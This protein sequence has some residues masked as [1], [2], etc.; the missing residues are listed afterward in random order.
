MPTSRIRHQPSF[1]RELLRRGELT[2][3]L[4]LIDVG[5]SGGID[6]LWNV[7]GERLRAVGFDPLVKEVA[8]LN[9]ENG[10]PKVNY[11]AAFV[12]C[13]RIPEVTTSSNPFPRTSAAAAA[14]LLRMNY[15]QEKFNAG[16]QVVWSDR[17]VDLDEYFS[18]ADAPAVDF[19]KIDTDGHDFH[20]LLGAERLLRDGGVL[21]LSVESQLH[22]DSH[23]HANTFANLDRFLRGLGFMLFDLE[24]H[25]YSRAVLPSP[26]VC[27]IPAQT[28]DGQVQWGEAVYFRDL[29]AMTT[30]D[31]P[32]RWGRQKLLKLASLFE[33]FGLADCAVEL[34][35]QHRA[36][37]PELAGLEWLDLLT[38]PLHG[39]RLSYDRYL[40]RFRDVESFY[41]RQTS[42]DGASPGKMSRTPR[43]LAR[44]LYRWLKKAA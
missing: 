13:G 2:S 17:H 1:T 7:F 38:P 24:V 27:N 42:W 8:R 31:L 26:F 18:A 6:A 9:R 23:D 40:E 35:L 12:G 5:A 22:G 32:L 30:K 25:R 19:L 36:L 15:V 29:A 16:Q 28:R 14:D 43:S 44:L 20:V 41:P 33:L 21:G 3:D 10:R 37:W 34:L 39:K 11:E 4:F